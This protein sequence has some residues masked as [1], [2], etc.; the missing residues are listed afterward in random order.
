MQAEG[1]AVLYSAKD[2]INFLGCHHSVALDLDV[3][4]RAPGAPEDVEDA[5]LKL[6]Q[7]KGNAHERAYLEKLKAEGKS[8]REI[9]RV[10][11]LDEMTEATRQAMRDGVDVIYQ[12][13]LRSGQWHG[14]SDFLLR[15]AVPSNLGDYS[16]RRSRRHQAGA[17]GAAKTRRA[18]V[19]LLRARRA[20]AGRAPQACVRRA[21]RQQ[22]HDAQGRRLPPLCGRV[23]RERFE[24]VYCTGEHETDA[25][26]CSHCELCRWSERCD[27]E[28]EAADHLQL[29][30]RLGGAHAKKLRSAGVTNLRELAVLDE[31]PHPEDAAR[32]R[33]QPSRAG[34][35]PEREAHDG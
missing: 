22:H 4:A 5:Y 6:L 35:A 26:P 21:R 15:V 10:K 11:S 8:V 13:A 1:A 18:A 3:A 29:V 34:S 27:D 31:S 2:L 16:L 30:A 20:R 25:E 17:D 7:D 12:G 23:V 19:H 9:A 32:D 14:Y 33:E 28:W 24:A